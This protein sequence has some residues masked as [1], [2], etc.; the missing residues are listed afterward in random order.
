MQ[1]IISA[2]IIMGMITLIPCQPIRAD[3][4]PKPSDPLAQ[5]TDLKLS[6]I[7][8]GYEGEPIP[9]AT[10]LIPELSRTSESDEKG[11]FEFLG[12][13]PGKYHIEVFAEGYM[14]YKSDIFELKETGKAFTI[15]LV[16]KLSEE[17]VVT[18]TR[19][20]KLYMEVPVK[21]QVISA[22]QI[23]QKQATQLAE[24]ISLT[25]GVRVENNCQ[26][27]NFTQVRINGM[28]GKYS[29]ILIDNS[30]IFSSM[31]GVYGLE[32][33]PAE[34]LNRIEIVKGGGS[35]LYG[36]NAVAGVINV[37]TKEPMENSSTL[38][39]HQEFQSGEPLT[40]AGFRTSLV[41]NDGNTKG[42]LFAN[43]K[44]R[45]PVDID[46]DSFSEV[47]KMQS[48]NF[49][50]NF[51]NYFP[52]I[53]GKLKLSFFRITES[54]RGGNKFDL[55]PHEAD[56]AEAI[57]SNLNGLTGEW[58]HYLASRLFYNLGFSIV[59]A[60]RD[61]YYGAEQDLNAYGSS[62]NPVVFLNGQMNYQAGKHL[63]SGG[64]QF[65]GEKIEDKALG[66]GREIDDT[67]RELGLF[68]QDD[69]KFNSTVSLLAGLRMSKHSL[70][71]DL[72][73]NP[74][75]SLL[76]NLTGDLSWRTTFSTGFRAPQVFDEDLHITQV[77]GEGMIIE[78]SPDLTQE[79]SYSLSS[80]LDFGRM[81]GNNNLQLSLE[82]FYTLLT[83]TF[84]LTE[85]EFDPRENALVFERIN[86]SNSKV[87]GVSAEF[88]LQFSS[89]FAIM[90]GWTFQ[91]SRL[92]EPEPDFGSTDLFRTPD[93][94]GYVTFN[95]ENE[96]LLDIDISL[97]YTGRMKVP[98]YAGY[99]PED[100]LETSDP[101]WVL[102]AK[103]TKPVSLGLNN[104][105]N[106]FLGAYNLFNSFQKDLDKGVLRDAGYVYGPS[107]PRAFYAG[108]EFI[109]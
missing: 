20:P 52:G 2:I 97:E 53:D 13:P 55:P 70:I 10:I 36:G 91:R 54:R 21:T 73:F 8:K 26:N 51:F 23:D 50:L 108:F 86:G 15:T 84:I 92:D 76:L 101:F 72:I 41:T 48:T 16:K 43:Y 57:D 49:G 94:Y 71:S 62:N 37:Q 33:I 98:H 34:M 56:I 29:Q 90:S 78:N 81:I 89:S 74:R 40:N 1:K 104:T 69:V 46:G 58:N 12:I 25:T 38:N 96:R 4:G 63:L 7:I 79:S 77:G 88:G 68:L 3:V 31:I 42:F 32:Q 83:D 27:C 93:A 82:G 60:K 109:F 17:I 80:G 14:D 85:Q 67:Y 22:R 64:I 100:Q 35:A 28:E 6:G 102:N 24:A 11:V 19:T 65:K 39:L 44:R 47:G 105:I 9:K 66:Y 103:M 59:D 99:I 61:T 107:K 45:D 95:Y 87:Y 5:A 30:P 75:L 106:F 18:A